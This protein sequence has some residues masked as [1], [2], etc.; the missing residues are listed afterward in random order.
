MTRALFARAALPMLL[1]ALSGCDGDPASGTD[2]AVGDDAG[3]GTDAAMMT[4]D[5]RPWLY[6]VNTNDDLTSYAAASTAE[7]DVAP[8]TSLALGASTMLFQPRAIAITDSG[9][10]L[11][12]RQ[13]GGIVAWDALASADGDTAADHVIEDPSLGTVIAFAYDATADRLFV[14]VPNAADGVLVYDDVSAAG[15][16]GSVAPSRRF[17]PA[18]RAPHD[19]SGSIA[20]TVDAFAFDAAGAL[21]VVDTSGLSV[22]HSRILVFDAPGTADGETAPART[23]TTET[24]DGLVDIAIDGAGNLVAVDDT[25][26]I[27]VVASVST[28]DGD[29]T[30]EVLTIAADRAQLTGVLFGSDGTGYVS[31]GQNA[32]VYVFDS[33]TTSGGT[34]DRVIDGS[35]TGLRGPG[36]MFLGE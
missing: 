14:G 29:I 1:L 4:G 21:Y 8:R 35:A 31:D 32:S 19:P 7:G 17:G 13:N 15:F 25:S 12:G 26:A 22:N 2:A 24:W 36:H 27:Y 28:A 11:V 20:M 5:A 23:L 10:L 18:D 9:R 16:D 33:L 6:V 34:P 30:P 3:A